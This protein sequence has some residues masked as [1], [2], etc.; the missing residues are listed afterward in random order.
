MVTPA[1]IKRLA[2]FA[3][4]VGLIL[5]RWPSEEPTYMNSACGGEVRIR[6]DGFV[7]GGFTQPPGETENVN[8]RLVTTAW[9]FGQQ[10]AMKRF[11]PPGGLG[12]NGKLAVWDGQGHR[13]LKVHPRGELV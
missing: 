7:M 12:D 1:L 13:F 8:D 5:Y 4:V 9:N 11:A 3:P 6:E 10:Q 2:T